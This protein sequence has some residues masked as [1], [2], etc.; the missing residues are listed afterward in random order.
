MLI[1]T[2]AEQYFE[3]FDEKT[4]EVNLCGR[5]ACKRLMQMCSQLYPDVI[6]GSMDTGYMNIKAIKD[7]ARKQGVI[8]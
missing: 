6:F 2:F 5:D 3:V 7:A 4:G 8:E 1:L